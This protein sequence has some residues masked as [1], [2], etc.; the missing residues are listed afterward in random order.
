MRSVERGVA[1]PG[2]PH[3]AAYIVCEEALGRG[4]GRV[5]CGNAGCAAAGPLH[6]AATIC[7]GGEEAL[8]DR[9][10][11][12][13]PR[14]GTPQQPA[15][16]ACIHFALDTEVAAAVAEEELRDIAAEGVTTVLAILASSKAHLS[17]AAIESLA[18]RAE[19][20]GAARV[21]VVDP[22]DTISAGAVVADALSTPGVHAVIFSSPCTRLLRSNI[23]APVDIDRYACVGCHRCKQI[24]GCP[25][26]VFAPPAYQIDADACTGC[27]LCTAYCRTHVIYSPR[28]RM[29]PEE[30][31][32]ERLAAT[33]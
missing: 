2:C 24:T 23:P 6:P 17:R 20:L 26:L 7:P 19:E 25:A 1:C 22:L 16:D 9:Y 31:A 33:R 3:R 13:V 12:P 8:L 30:R 14:G 15:V 21:A 4:A 29:T 11:T 28:T 27:D 5:I 10:R 18:A 32:A